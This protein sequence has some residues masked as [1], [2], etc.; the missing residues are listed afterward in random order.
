MPLSAVEPA[1]RSVLFE[2]NGD[3]DAGLPP[4]VFGALARRDLLPDQARA[5]RRG[6]ALWM[7]IGIDALP[8]ALL[9]ALEADL[10]RLVGVRRLSVM[11]RPDR[12]VSRGPVPPGDLRAA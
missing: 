11:L 1:C 4:R 12:P 6:D 3:P 2:L 9:P 5:G 10:R 8:G 7:E